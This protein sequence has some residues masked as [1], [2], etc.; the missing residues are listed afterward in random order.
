MSNISE[1][2][3]EERV[4]LGMTQ[5]EFGALVGVKNAAQ[6]KY[7]SGRSPDADYLSVITAAG[8]DVLYILT[9][10]RMVGLVSPE[11]VEVLKEDEREVLG[12]YRRSSASMRQ[13]VMAVIMALTQ[14]SGRGNSGG[15]NQRQQ[16]MDGQWQGQ[17]SNSGKTANEPTTIL[18]GSP[19]RPDRSGNVRI[20]NIRVKSGDVR[21]RSGDIHT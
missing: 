8:A 4:R 1:R 2:I 12:A 3:R 18:N 20:R 15:M 5:S 6:S 11:N 9:G 17:Q 13:Q 19:V 21:I 14:E 7:E 16:E 10:R